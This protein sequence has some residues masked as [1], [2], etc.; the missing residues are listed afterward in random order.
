MVSRRT[1]LVIFLL[2][3]LPYLLPE[4]EKPHI[5]KAKSKHDIEVM[6]RNKYIGGK[7]DDLPFVEF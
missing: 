7:I 1:V 6:K 5:Y 4:D 3:F 2:S